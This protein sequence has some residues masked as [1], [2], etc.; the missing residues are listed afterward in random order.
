VPIGWWVLGEACRQVARWTHRHP[1]A[2]T[3]TIGVNLSVRQLLADDFAERIDAALRESGLAAGRLRL[4]ITEH[5]LGQDL[6]APAEALRAIR[7][8]GVR[9]ALDKFGSGQSSLTA[10]REWPVDTLKLAPSFGHGLAGDARS[11]AI[12]EAV[13]SL[14]AK[15]GMDV[16]A[17][18]VETAD[19]M[20]RVRVLG[21]DVGQGF[22]FA[23][24]LPSDAVGD[25]LHAGG[26]Y[27]VLRGALSAVGHFGDDD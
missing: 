3:V 27:D 1:E 6:R 5:M 24:P 15:L 21:C 10:L 20:V 14:A 9:V 25:F 13:G 4:E 19:Q 12:V 26:T 8:R 17:E 11:A 23:P 22:F 2:A 16:V 7:T 18:G